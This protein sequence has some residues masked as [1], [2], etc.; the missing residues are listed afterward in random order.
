MDLAIKNPAA[1]AS[2]NRVPKIVAI[3]KPLDTRHP[4]ETAPEFQSELLAIR[5]VMRRCQV[6]F[7]HAKTICQLSG[8]GGAA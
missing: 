3:A 4:T 1:P 8:L 6:T 5:A 7:W 2:A